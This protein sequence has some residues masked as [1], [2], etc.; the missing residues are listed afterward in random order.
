MNEWPRDRHSATAQEVFSI[1]GKLWNLTYVVQAGMYVVWR[2]LRLTGLHVSTS[3]NQSHRVE[4]GREFHDDMD[5]W[6]WTIDEELLITGASLNAPCFAAVK[7]P[8]KRLYLSDASFDAIGGYCLELRIYWRYDLPLDCS[9]KLKRKAANRETSSVTINLLE[10]VGMVVTAWVMQELVGD[11]PETRGDPILMRGDNVAAFTWS[12]RCGGARDM[13]A[14][15]MM[16]MLGCLEISGGWGYNA[17]HIPGIQ[18]TLAEGISRWPRSQLAAKV[19][20]LTN[21]NDWREQAIGTRG[22]RLL[23]TMRISAANKEHKTPSRPHV[24]EPHYDPP[25]R[26]RNKTLDH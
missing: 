20:Q 17:K 22:N 9:A 15:L 24:V 2:L 19:R 13:R 14:C 25:T 12:N 1:A 16:R 26:R 3:K 7:R 23:L 6:R 5:F 4:L 8:A 21:S 18:N 10:L 11:R